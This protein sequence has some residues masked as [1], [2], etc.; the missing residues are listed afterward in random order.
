[1]EKLSKKKMKN[2]LY[3]FISAFML[4]ACSKTL[5]IDS[6]RSVSEPNMWKTLEDTRAGIMGVYALTRAALSDNNCHW[7]YGDVRGGDFLSPKRQDL[8]AVIGNNLNASYPVIEAMSNWTRF[9]AVVNSANVFLENVAKVKANDR[10]Y[11]ESNMLVDM[12]QARFLRAYAYFYMVRIWGDVP[13]ILSSGEGSFENKPR[14]SQARIMAWVEQEMLKAATDLPFVYSNND[15]QQPGNYYNEDPG[16][17]GGA[18]VTKNSAYGVLAHVAAWV[19]D[20]SRV[21]GY[22]RFVL[23]NYGKSGINYTGTADLT[24]PNG[25]FWNKNNRQMLG[26]NSDWGHIDGSVTGH[27]EELTLAEPVT[28]KVVPDIYIPKDTVLKIFNWPNDDRFSIDT[29]G[30]PRNER[31]FTNFNGKYPIFSKIKSIQGGSTDPNFRY[32]TSA[33]VFT[34]LEDVLLLRAEALAVL[35]DRAG[36]ISELINLQSRRLVPNITDVFIDTNRDVVDLIFE[37]RHRELLGE[38]HRWYDLIRYNKIKQSNQAF[39]NLIASG[40]IYWP[41]SRKLISRNTLLTQNAYWN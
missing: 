29:L 22:T 15:P 14:E 24:N 21:A 41:I 4:S 12:A 9:Y 23:D 34:R 31:Y 7:I 28:N 38:G 1:M 19:G 37:E 3:L 2:I 17:W 18:L 13:F 10:R 20:Y 11:T 36:A 6:V 26:F 39:M 16:R 40:G 32:F 5:D 8:K 30:Q 33:L 25:F 27:L 35:G